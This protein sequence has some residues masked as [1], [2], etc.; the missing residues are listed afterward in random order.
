MSARGATGAEG[1]AEA[2]AAL[3]AGNLGLILT[4]RSWSK[5]IFGTFR[6]R[7]PALWL[8]VG[9]AAGTL[10]LVLTVPA[11]RD[12][13]QFGDVRPARVLLAVAAGLAS[14]VWIE[15]VKLRTRRRLSG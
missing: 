10:A 8:V 6:A 1:R 3:I 9:G 2:F 4:N 5:N 13:F 14:I 11:L 7:N 15:I 12:V